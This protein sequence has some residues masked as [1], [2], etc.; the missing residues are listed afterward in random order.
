MSC[1]VFDGAVC[2]DGGLQKLTYVFLTQAPFDDLWTWVF[3]T[4]A[5]FADLWTLLIK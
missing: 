3:F 1:H 4:Q 2:L 5:R